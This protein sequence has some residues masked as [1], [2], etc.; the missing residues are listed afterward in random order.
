MSVI[1]ACIIAYQAEDKLKDT[2]ESIKDQV[3]HIVVGIDS[4]TTDKTE[5]VAR[6]F[7]A[8]TYPFDLDDDF[9]AARDL[10]FSK[11]PEDT[12][13]YLWIDS[14]DILAFDIPLHQLADEQGPDVGMVW[15]PYVY[16]RDEYGNVT[17][18][19]D[20]ERLIRKSSS[21][22]WHGR[23]HET[24]AV[25]AGRMSRDKRVWTE[26]TNRTDDGKGER[27]FRILNKMVEA[28][29]NDHRA[30]LYLAHQYFAA[31]NWTQAAKW[32][33]KFIGLSSV[34]DVV[35]EKWQAMIYLAKSRRSAGDVNGSIR[36]AREAM[37]MCPKYADSYFELAHSYALKDD[38]TRS[39]HW[40]EQGLTK[41]QPDNILILNPL[42]YS[43]NPFVISHRVY[44]R[45]NKLEKALEDVSTAIGFRPKDTG[46]INSAVHYQWAIGRKDTVD[47]AIR[48]SEFLL[49]TNEP[50]KARAVL[51]NLPAGIAGGTV[52]AARGI[53]EQRLAHLSDEVA[54]DN[55]YFEEPDM[56]DPK[57]D[58]KFPRVDW[59]IERLKAMGAKKILEVG[60]GDGTPAF[61]YAAEGFQVV[62]IDIEPRRIQKAKRVAV[63]LG[64]LKTESSTDDLSGLITSNQQRID[65][66][67]L[68]IVI[69]G[70]QGALEQKAELE[71]NLVGLEARA[72]SLTEER[73]TATILMTGDSPVSFWYGS[74]EDVPQK[75]KDM[76]PFDAVI[77]SEILE[78][79][80][81]PEKALDQADKL[82]KHVIVTTPDGASS[83]QFFENRSDPD[84]THSL[85]VRAYSREELDGLL[86]KRGRLIESH[87]LH[88]TNYIICAEY[89]VGDSILEHPPVVIY[90]GPGL[91]EWTPEQIDRE[92]LGGSETAVVKVAEELVQKGLRVMVYGPSEGVWNGVFYRHY[93]KF[94][95]GNPIVLFISWRNPSLFDLPLNAQVKFLWAHDTDFGPALTEERAKKI[96][97]VMALS[98][99]HVQ[100]LRK[101]YPFLGEVFIVGNG[102]DPSRFDGVEERVP[103]RFAYTSSPDRGLEQAL[104]M[105]PDVRKAIP[106]AELHVFYGWENYDK[107]RRPIEFKA[108]IA[109]LAD[110]PGIVWHGRTG[111]KELARELMKCGALFY[112][113]PHP[114]EETF[115]I[116]ALEAQAA[117]AIPVTRNNGAL[118][119]TNKYG[120]LL[121]S[122]SSYK[123]Y[124][125]ALRRAVNSTGRLKMSDWAKTQTWAVVSD[126]LLAQTRKSFAAS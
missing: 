86:W 23:L 14:D 57:F 88:D 111:Q 61:R 119:E 7:G 112:P 36:A 9:A 105:W 87:L 79:V 100:H 2:L 93:K 116:A 25:S 6:S 24:C 94:E 115:C 65:W 107:S 30:V 48:M 64:Y 38:W 59:I 54:Y 32:Y 42:D 56:P 121:S 21:P 47:S 51:A 1:T 35:E 98:E 55:A 90:C 58:W 46:L 63:K 50:L 103:T 72:K 84:S 99:W 117:G 125:K 76:G 15:V 37:M 69:C 85:H 70:E 126:R 113:G 124:I 95:P 4:K 11:A 53:V 83:Y 5:E 16:H 20:R 43:F 109:R 101:T 102:I 66:T 80:V 82:G 120:E 73:D 22:K 41:D 45:L 96:D 106:K 26:H 67:K 68:Q 74:A 49:D 44:F 123:G 97:A 77:L 39:A 92:G 52:D 122:S 28:D 34:G 60:I 8:L 17:T 33:E 19:F 81:D 29:A 10:S 118:P 108:H 114:F 62:G 110:Q 27:N 40:H 91:E 31:V 78:H 104:A 18:M 3:D 12:E 75:I 13:W 71:G 89:K